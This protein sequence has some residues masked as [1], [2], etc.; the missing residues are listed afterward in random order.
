MSLLGTFNIFHFGKEVFQVGM[1][2]IIRQKSRKFGFFHPPTRHDLFKDVTKGLGVVPNGDGE[3]EAMI[4]AK[5]GG[6]MGALLVWRVRGGS[7]GRMAV[8]Q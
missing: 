1:A 5:L 6:D 2:I 4:G 3:S 7:M 8:G